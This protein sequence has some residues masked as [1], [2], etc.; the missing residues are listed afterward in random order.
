M[1]WRL[2]MPTI[3]NKPIARATVKPYRVTCHTTWPDDCGK[4]IVIRLTETDEIELRWAGARTRF[5]IPIAELFRKLQM[6]GHK[7]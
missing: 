3:L 5:T 6:N 4:R 1:D 7:K 2:K